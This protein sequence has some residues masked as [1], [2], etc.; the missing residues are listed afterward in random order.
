MSKRA[1]NP[2][3]VL[4]LG[5]G[6]GLSASIAH[7]FGHEG[8]TITLLAR[9]EQNVTTLAQELRNDVDTAT[10]DAAD[11]KGFRAA[12]EKLAERITPG[13]VVL[14]R[15]DRGTTA[16]AVRPDRHRRR[17]GAQ[18]PRGIPVRAARH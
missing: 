10:A 16:H 9:S 11:P 15:L 4:I 18:Q 6:P 14:G 13:V 8:Y 3:H 17:A 12:I 2:K 1:I 5:A 7:R